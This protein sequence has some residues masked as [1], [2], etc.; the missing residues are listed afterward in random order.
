LSEHPFSTGCRMT[1]FFPV[2]TPKITE[3]IIGQIRD[4]ILDGTTRPGDRLPAEQELVKRFNASRIAVREALKALE[5][6]GLLTIRPGSG[7]FVANTGSTKMSES[8]YSILRIENISLNEVTESRLIFEPHVAR[9]A[10]ERIT[11]EDLARLRDNIES[12]LAVVKSGAPATAENIEFH[13]LLA[14]S[15]HNTVIAM[16]MKTMLEV[17]REMTSA[18][19]ETLA[20]RTKVSRYSVSDHRKI[21]AALAEKNPQKVYELMYEHIVRIQRDLKNVMSEPL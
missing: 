17:A 18:T 8:L 7:V 13:T 19:E 16:T 6:S 1:S 9:L 4:A 3:L 5:A 12:T 20:Q 14:E 11:Q 10:G 21:L 2:K 15:T